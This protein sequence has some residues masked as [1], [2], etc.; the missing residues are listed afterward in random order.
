MDIRELFTPD[1]NE[2][3]CGPNSKKDWMVY[4]L[5]GNKLVVDSDTLAILDSL[6]KIWKKA[7]VAPDTLKEK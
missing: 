4:N 6:S 5:S 1:K 3:F 7:T 2:S